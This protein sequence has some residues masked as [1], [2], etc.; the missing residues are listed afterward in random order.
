MKNKLKLF[1]IPALIIFSPVTVLALVPTGPCVGATGLGGLL[2]KL[3]E[4]LNSIIPVLLALGVVYFVW[5][6]VQYVIANEEE[7]K[8]KGRERIIYGIIGLAIIVSL[9]GLVNI[10]VTTFNLDSNNTAPDVSSLVV[11][12]TSSAGCT[13]GT[14]FQGLLDYATCIIGKSVI[15]FIFAIAMVMFVW[16]AVKFFIIDADEEAKRAQGKQ[17]MIWGI[18][19][20]TVMIS[21]WGLVNVLGTTFNLRTNVLPQIQ[22]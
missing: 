1:L 16:G 14:K 5:G 2:C 7:V 18:I 13:L 4:L 21:V 3:N 10:V 19:A 6:V 15:P 9:W 12:S 17:F 20:L 11:T 22:P 8:K